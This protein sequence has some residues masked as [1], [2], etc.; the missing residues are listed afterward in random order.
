MLLVVGQEMNNIPG[1]NDCG[2]CG[3]SN[4]SVV[5]PPR[6]TRIYSRLFYT[7]VFSTPLY[8]LYTPLYMLYVPLYML[9]VPRDCIRHTQPSIYYV[10]VCANCV[11]GM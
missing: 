6:Q 4:A 5:Y 8:M 2:D 7:P 1:M 10:T 9:Y 3:K 11:R